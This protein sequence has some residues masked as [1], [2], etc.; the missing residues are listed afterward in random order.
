MVNVDKYAGDLLANNAA[1]VALLGTA[2]KIQQ[3]Y[4]KSF[5]DLPIVT[6]SIGNDAQTGRL[7]FDDNSKGRD[8]AIN[9]DLWLSANASPTA[10]IDAVVN[11]MNAEGFFMTTNKNVPDLNDEITHRHMVFVAGKLNEQL[12]V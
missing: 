5:N 2:N 12:S 4:P 10:L 7:N 11:L 6:F 9:V 8:L 1:L 3:E